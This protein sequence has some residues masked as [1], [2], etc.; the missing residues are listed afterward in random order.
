MKMISPAFLL[1]VFCHIQ[2]CL[3]FTV[4][5]NIMKYTT[6]SA[7]CRAVTLRARKYPSK[8]FDPKAAI[9]YLSATSLQYFLV[10]SFMK[11][12]DEWLLPLLS[13]VNVGKQKAVEVAVI[14]FMLGLS[15][16]S[17]VF[18]PL[19]NTRPKAT[20]DDPVFKNRLRPSWQPSPKVF[21]VIWSSISILRTAA[22]FAV[23]KKTGSLT[24]APLLAFYAHLAIGDTWNTINNVE[25][26]LGTAFL[27]VLFVLASVLFT[28]QS[29]FSVLPVAGY[30]MAP[31]C[32]WLSIATAL[33]FSIWRLNYDRFNGPSLL[34][35]KE[36]GPPSKWK[37]P[38]IALTVLL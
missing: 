37:V 26:R 36:E 5:A 7:H 27:G 24:S 3:T 25:G 17:R 4:P 9:S 13:R 31:T 20:Y 30:F 29:Y 21:P 15:L 10:K 23:Y 22:A 28:T 16:R 2:L 6:T 32:L 8:Q 1:L 35:S 38:L 18:S 19:N 12:A 34:P 33:I 14:A 11:N